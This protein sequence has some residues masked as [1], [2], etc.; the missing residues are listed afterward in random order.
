VKYGGVAVGRRNGT[1][2]VVEARHF[3]SFV[4]VLPLF[5]RFLQLGCFSIQYIGDT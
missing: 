2:R 5:A 4:S 1:V 3:P